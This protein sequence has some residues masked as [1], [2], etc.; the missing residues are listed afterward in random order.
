MM[1]TVVYNKREAEKFKTGTTVDLVVVQCTCGLL[2]GIPE[3]LNRSALKHRGGGSGG[4][5]I[6]CPLGHTWH[7]TDSAK[8]EEAKLREERERSHSANLVAR[9]DQ[10][11]AS[12]SAT[13][14]VVTRMKRRASAG[15]CPCCNRTFQQLARHMETKHPSFVQSRGG[16]LPSDVTRNRKDFGAVVNAVLA[17]LGDDVK[18][19]IEIKEGVG[20]TRGH[21]S[22]ILHRMLAAGDVER[23][24]HGRYRK[25]SA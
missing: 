14:G 10:T 6:S 21:T 2:F 23:V 20:I 22:N 19:W 3:M 9:L 13:K 24:S 12:L 25:K 1:P 15:T 11:Q 8:D 16:Q 18:A 5:S 4:W 7:Y 17:F